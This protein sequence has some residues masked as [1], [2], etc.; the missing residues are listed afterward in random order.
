MV[1]I[2]LLLSMS[3]YLFNNPEGRGAG[4]R[5]CPQNPHFSYLLRRYILVDV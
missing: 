4:R 5:S 3:V 1:A 2:S